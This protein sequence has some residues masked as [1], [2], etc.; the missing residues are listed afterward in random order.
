MVIRKVR[1]FIVIKREVLNINMNVNIRT[2]IL[3]YFAT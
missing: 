3:D 2:S 1:G